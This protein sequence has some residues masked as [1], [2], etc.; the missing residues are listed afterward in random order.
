MPSGAVS[1]APFNRPPD[2]AVIHIP[3][4][5]LNSITQAAEAAYPSECCGL[6]VGRR[7]KDGDIHISRVEPSPN[8]AEGDRQKSFLVDAKVHFDLIRGLQDGPDEIVGN[9][10]S[11]PGAPAKPSEHDRQSVY[12][13]DHVWIIVAVDD[14][15]AGEVAAYVFDR[16]DGNFHEVGLA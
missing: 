14:G 9:Y 16:E 13:P 6:L 12:Y 11:H 2:P 1:S 3:E 4:N 7:E 10:H 15:L 8:V 5:L